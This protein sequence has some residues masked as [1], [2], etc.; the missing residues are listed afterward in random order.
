MKNG[1][2]WVR[3]GSRSLRRCRERFSGDLAVAGHV[4]HRKSL[5]DIP[6]NDWSV[7]EPTIQ[8]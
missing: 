6:L 3:L 2:S 7:V 5:K 8:E 1:G 4:H